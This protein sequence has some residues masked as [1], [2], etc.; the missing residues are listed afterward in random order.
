ML[1][2]VVN[3]DGV[4]V[5]SYTVGGIDWTA[6]IDTGFNGGLELPDALRGTFPE[7]PAA[8]V[9][10]FLGG[11]QAIHQQ[12]FEVEFPFDGRTVKAHTTF[13]PRT[14]ILI[15]TGLLQDYRL[16]VNFVTRT[17]ILERLTP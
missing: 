10:Y 7:R 15:G 4:P 2:G 9:I 14:D 17:V 3:V 16:E 11:G 8:P 5:I 13:A 1:V 6:I 12:A